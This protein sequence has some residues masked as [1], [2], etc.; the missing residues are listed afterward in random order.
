T[1]WYAQAAAIYDAHPRDLERP[2]Y[3]RTER[4]LNDALRSR[5][6]VLLPA[7]NAVQIIRAL[8]LAEKLKLRVVLYGGQ[9]GYATAEAIAAKR[10]PVLVS[11]KWPEKEKDADPEAEEPLRGRR[12][13]DRAPSTPAAPGTRSAR[14]SGPRN[15]PRPT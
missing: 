3:D 6:L 8:D 10:V 7:N 9:Q 13:R 11:L 15:R 14:S 4:V 2:A 5:Q 1:E 12:L